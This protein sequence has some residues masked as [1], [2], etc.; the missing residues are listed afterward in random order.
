MESFSPVWVLEEAELT[1]TQV[2]HSDRLSG[3]K[4]GGF[5]EKNLLLEMI[6]SP[7]YSLWRVLIH[8]GMR[9]VQM[10]MQDHFISIE[11]S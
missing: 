7:L 2:L 4:S 5:S 9:A 11:L 6:Y 8:T 1:D 3:K 10:K